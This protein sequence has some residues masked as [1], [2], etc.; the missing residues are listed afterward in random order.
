[1]SAEIALFPQTFLTDFHNG[2]SSLQRGIILNHVSTTNA[3]QIDTT[4]KQLLSE[5]VPSELAGLGSLCKR[6]IN[7]RGMINNQDVTN[8]FPG[9]RRKGD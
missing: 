2:C 4:G 9:S 1:M 3:M 7:T 6:S 8:I 5:L